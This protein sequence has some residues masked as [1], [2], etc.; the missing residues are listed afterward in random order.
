MAEHEGNPFHNIPGLQKRKMTLITLPLEPE[1]K[2]KKK[3]N[4]ASSKKPAASIKEKE[5]HW[6]KL[7]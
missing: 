3:E 4:Y 1:R 2:E 7:P 6:S 5:T